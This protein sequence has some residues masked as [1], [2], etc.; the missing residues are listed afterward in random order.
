[1]L[2]LL[3]KKCISSI[4]RLSSLP[5]GNFLDGT[6]PT[7]GK[8]DSEQPGMTYV[9]TRTHDAIDYDSTTDSPD[10]ENTNTHGPATRSDEKIVDGRV[11]F[12]NIK[13]I[14]F[15]EISS[16]I[17]D[18]NH[19][20]K[21]RN[22]DT[23]SIQ[24]E[25]ARNGYSRSPEAEH[26]HYKIGMVVFPPFVNEALE[27][28]MKKN[29]FKKFLKE[30][31]ERINKIAQSIH[32]KGP[33]EADSSH[34][35]IKRPTSVIPENCNAQKKYYLLLSATMLY[36]QAPTYL[37]VPHACVH[38]CAFVYILLRYERYMYVHFSGAG[39]AGAGIYGEGCAGFCPSAV[40]IHVCSC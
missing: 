30:D 35:A 24:K 38:I 27:R 18:K 9:N 37:R 10:T 34:S 31:I 14:N 36:V 3:R 5:K 17:L 20:N 13:D 29:P 11:Y 26:G 28:I 7:A 39:E 23:G 2:F 16:M 6:R 25:P 12:E 32:Q 8:S 1:M 19:S 21:H 15:D 4:R 33:L 40:S 22:V